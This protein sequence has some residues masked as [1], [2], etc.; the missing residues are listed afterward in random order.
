M[1]KI[2]TLAVAALAAAGM[3][4]QHG[5]MTFVGASTANVMKMDVPNASDT[6]KFEVAGATSG[7]ITIPALSATGMA[8]I[9]SFTISGAAFTMGENHAITITEQTFTAT[10][11][12]DGEEKTITGTSL[13]GT[14]NMADNC[15]DLKAVFTYGKMPL[16]LTYTVKAYYV[17][18]V[19][20][21]I[22][23]TVGGAYNYSNE[24]VTYNV[25]KYKEDGI[26]RLDVQIPTYQLTGTVMG[27]LTLGTYTVKGLYYD[28]EKGGF[29]RDYRDDDLKFHFTAVNGGKTTMDG[30]YM[31]NVAKDNNLL[32]KYNGSEIADIINTFQMGAMPF[33]IVSKFKA[34]S[35]GISSATTTGVKKDGKMYNLS[36]QQ[37]SA[38]YKGVV[39]VNGKK[40]LNY[41]R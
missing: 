11:T 39:I 2:F 17:K 29:Y 37:V 22:D 7:N 14:Y 6:V 13:S 20:H 27:D 38:S 26:D 21:A 16:P 30:D 31:F 28:E 8:S 25:R 19:A 3:K 36:G 1:K 12:A 32:V 24:S 9:P 40:Y 34:S 41:G 35:T 33:G 10:V 15:L 5:P 18:P 23:V 4:A